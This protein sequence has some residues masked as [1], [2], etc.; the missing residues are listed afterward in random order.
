[1][2]V[3]EPK[4]V[5]TGVPGLDP[6]LQG[7]LLPCRAY[8]VCGGPGTGKTTLGLQ[9]LAAAGEPSLLVSLAEAVQDIRDDAARIGLD[10]SAVSV[11]D[12]S[13]GEA[14]AARASYTLVE[15][16]EAEAPDLRSRIDALCP[17][18]PPARVFV[19]AL[20]QLRH[21]VPDAFQF[22]K[23][24]MALLQYLTRAGATVLFTA[25]RGSEAEQDLQYL[26]DGIVRLEQAEAG[27]TLSVHKCRGTGF[28]EGAHAVR[29]TQHGMHVYPRLL[30][31][32]HGQP[33]STEAIPFGVTALDALTGGGIER[34]T[35]T[36]IS[37]PTGVGKTSLGTQMMR[38]AARRGE[39]S[40]IFTFEEKLATLRHRCEQIGIPLADMIGEGT[41]AVEEV[42]PLRYMPDEFAWRVRREVEEQ[43]ARVVMLDSLSGYRQSL[44]GEAL[45]PHIHALC[46][47]LANMGVTVLLVNEVSTIAGAD[48]RV[49]DHGISYLADAVLMLRY[50]ELRGELRKTIGVL[51]KRT[52]DFEKTLREFE[53]SA[54]GLRVGEPLTGLRGILR[55]LPEM[56]GEG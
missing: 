21:L 43:G 12:L 29:L 23:Q 56:L 28:G 35:V 1:M 2:S 22:R 49:S 30:P 31:E 3:S 16:W 41:L 34:G 42:E 26:G 15:P 51:K 8:L 18:G 27:R 5:P 54:E 6:V 10:L 13:P 17:E 45:T 50:I 46:R 32:D 25:E 38:E 20:S 14:D 33:F 24:V 9:F 7:G 39:R 47:Y 53:I 36:I 37:G 52:G 44:R 55:G 40:V 11:L 4:R 48:I 19:D